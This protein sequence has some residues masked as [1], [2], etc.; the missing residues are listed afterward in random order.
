[1]ESIGRRPANDWF[2]VYAK[3][4]IVWKEDLSLGHQS[5][6]GLDV[7]TLC[8]IVQDVSNIASEDLLATRTSVNADHSDANGPR[9]IAN[10]HLQVR[11]IRS[12]IVA[13]QKVTRNV[14][15][16]VENV[17]RYVPL[18]ERPEERLDVRHSLHVGCAGEFSLDRSLPLLGTTVQF[19][20]PGPEYHLQILQD[21]VTIQ[22]SI[23]LAEVL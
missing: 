16:A 7:F 20:S 23:T 3:R 4:R 6:H 5:L 15:Q 19:I 2:K 11:V 22:I 14:N 21:D 12:E 18:L 13:R 17:F 8:F 10:C 9:C 1:M